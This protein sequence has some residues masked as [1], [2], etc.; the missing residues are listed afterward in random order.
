MNEN[1]IYERIKQVLAD[2]PRNQY[3]AE[4]HLQMIKYADELKNIT[5]KE[6]CEG[7]GLRSSFGTEFSKMRNLTPRLKAAGLQTELI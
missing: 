4:L 7:V 1:E 2:A 5:A 3:T 6:F